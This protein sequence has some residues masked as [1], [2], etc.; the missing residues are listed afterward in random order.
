[1]N[2]LD[3]YSPKLNSRHKKV[4]SCT[5]T[6]TLS[7][8]NMPVIIPPNNQYILPFGDKKMIIG[9]THQTVQELDTNISAGG[10]HYMLEQAIKMAPGITH[11]KFSEARSGFRP[12]TKNHLPVFGAL[13]GI[14][15]LLI[16]NGLGASGLT[17][18][19]FIANQLAKIISNEQ[20]D[21][22]PARYAIRLGE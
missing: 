18:G 17:T 15:G 14:Q 19:P 7:T 5:E 10:L 1:M 2:F 3:H 13:D 8:D 9:A 22:D 11:T 20:T 4:K 21:V 16:A 12:F 6:E